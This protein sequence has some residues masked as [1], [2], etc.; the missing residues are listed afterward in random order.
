MFQEGRNLEGGAPDP[1]EQEPA[2]EEEEQQPEAAEEAAE[3][4]AGAE[5]SSAEKETELTEEEQEEFENLYEKFTG[6]GDPEEFKALDLVEQNRRVHAH[7]EKMEDDE[8]SEARSRL[9]E[10][11]EKSG[12]YDPLE[13]WETTR[14]A[15]S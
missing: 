2:P 12:E 9:K 15:G 1:Y 13:G 3:T 11:L 6:K 8:R 4:E 7:M 10:L 5:D 14:E